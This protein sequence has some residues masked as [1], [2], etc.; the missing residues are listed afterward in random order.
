LLRTIAF[1]LK[2]RVILFEFTAEEQL[3]IMYANGNYFLIDPATTSIKQGSIFTED[4]TKSMSKTRC[5]GA[6]LVGDKVV[7]LK[8]KVLGVV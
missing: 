5:S 1:E 8:D 3:L 6:Q 4:D 2:E 7:I